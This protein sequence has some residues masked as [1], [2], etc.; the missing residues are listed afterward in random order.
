MVNGY[1]YQIKDLI[2]HKRMLETDTNEKRTERLRKA[3]RAE[4]NHRKHR[5]AVEVRGKGGEG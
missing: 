4:E 1:T 5:N 2:I 3:V